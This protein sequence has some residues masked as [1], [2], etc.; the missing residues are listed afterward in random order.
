MACFGRNVGLPEPISAVDQHRAGARRRS[1]AGAVGV[2]TAGGDCGGFARPAAGDSRSW[3]RAQ[4]GPACSIGRR[5]AGLFP[6]KTMRPDV[7]LQRLGGEVSQRLGMPQNSQASASLR[8]VCSLA[9]A[10]MPRPDWM[11]ADALVGDRRR[12]GALGR[13][14]RR[15]EAL[16]RHPLGGASARRCRACPPGPRCRTSCRSPSGRGSPCRRWSDIRRARRST[17]RRSRSRRAAR[18]SGCRR[19]RRRRSL[20]ERRGRGGDARAGRAWRREARLRHGG[21]RR[22]CVRKQGD[23]GDEDGG[24]TY[25]GAIGKNT[26]PD[27][28]TGIEVWILIGFGL[29]QSKS[30]EIAILRVRERDAGGKPRHTFPHPALIRRCPRVRTRR[31]RGSRSRSHRRA[32][33]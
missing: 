12:A 5:G 4:P 11:A 2:A 31:P 33:R 28:G 24:G 27:I 14:D 30:N 22:Q 8:W 10:Q 13:V 21:R 18:R 32:G 1:A 7:A 23:G 25:G 9:A 15:A 19:R 16:Q 26:L 20:P 6:A 3:A 29:V 17:R